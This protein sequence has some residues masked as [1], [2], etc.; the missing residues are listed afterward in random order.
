MDNKCRYCGKR[1]EDVNNTAYLTQRKKEEGLCLECKKE[2][3]EKDLYDFL[4]EKV[5]KICNE[6]NGG[7]EKELGKMLAKV[8]N[9]QHRHL[10]QMFFSMLFHCFKDYQSHDFDARNE[11]AVQIAKKWVQA[12][13]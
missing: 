7:D 9:G 8:L 6:L 10:Q 4:Q 5:E 12:A 2:I 1:K 3:T 13:E 11:W